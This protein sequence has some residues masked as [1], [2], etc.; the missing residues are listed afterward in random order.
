MQTYPIHT[1]YRK[2]LDTS[3]GKE[4]DMVAPTDS[5]LPVLPASL[6]VRKLPWS[7]CL[8]FKQ[9]LRWWCSLDKSAPQRLEKA[10]MLKIC[11]WLLMLRAVMGSSGF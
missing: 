2:L 4:T 5:A 6:H 3:N 7:L 10:P 8:A 11:V 9:T 1:I